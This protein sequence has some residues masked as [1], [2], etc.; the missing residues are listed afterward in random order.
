[1]GK[2]VE[3]I[4]DMEV[5]WLVSIQKRRPSP[6][7]GVGQQIQI[8][9]ILPIFLRFEFVGRLGLAQ[10]SPLLDGHWFAMISAFRRRQKRIPPFGTVS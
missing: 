6:D 5:L 8:L 1:V 2:D 10:N 9:K 7:S 3:I 4:V